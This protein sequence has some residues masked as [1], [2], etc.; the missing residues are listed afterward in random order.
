[1][2]T[3]LDYLKGIP[4]PLMGLNG[5]IVSSTEEWTTFRRDELLEL[6]RKHVYGRVPDINPVD[7]RFILLESNDKA[8]NG[9]AIR[10]QIRISVT[11]LRGEI[12]FTL[13]IF[14]PK[15]TKTPLPCFL[16]V[17]IRN[18]LEHY[19]L[20]AN[21]LI[22]NEY[23]PA[24]RIIERGYVA[25]RLI[26][27]EIDMDK[28]DHFKG[29]IHSIYE[30]YT[31]GQ[32]AKDAWGTIAAWA[33]GG[34]RAMDY[35][36]T[37]KDIDAK[38]VA[39][40]GHSRGGKTSLW[41]GAQDERFALVISNE[42][43]C[44]GAMLARAK[45]G[46]RVKD[47][48]KVFPHWFCENYRA[49]EDNE[50]A[51]PV[52]QHELLCLVAPRPLYVGSAEIDPEVAPMDEF[53]SLKLAEPVYGL[54]GIKG[55]K[56]NTIPPLNTSI[57]SPDGKLGYHVRQGHHALQLFDWEQYMNFADRNLALATV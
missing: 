9:K 41:C 48:N 5:R 57:V 46:E 3:A 14:T 37:D 28:D 32:R 4:N 30:N 47:I 49:F 25:A 44:T 17:D 15:E 6:F 16:L 38:R 23:W 53:N 21:R 52:D 51:M 1:M 35:F 26:L 55:L 40:I 22:Q 11:T 29:G 8:M 56:E 36:L 33:W 34:S 7:V 50:D 31:V 20:E 42:S 10:K 2:E 27:Q 18:P 12:G 39:V 24:E 54:F 45:R 19:T 13:L 43:G